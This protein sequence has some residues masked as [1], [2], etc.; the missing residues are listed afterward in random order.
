MDE[1]LSTRQ[2]AFYCGLSPRTLEKHRCVGGGPIYVKLGRLVKYRVVDIEEWIAG[3]R[4][5]STSDP[6]SAGQEPRG[7]RT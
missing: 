3:G 1:M 5:R 2:A 4:R 6:G 7:R